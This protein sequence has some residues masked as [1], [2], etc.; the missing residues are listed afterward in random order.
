MF[1]WICGEEEYSTERKE[2]E[3]MISHY[4]VTNADILVGIDL[5]VYMIEGSKPG[6]LLFVSEDRNELISLKNEGREEKRELKEVI[7]S[8]T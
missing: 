2:R 5:K 8:F 3:T 4:R 7:I 1:L 6:S